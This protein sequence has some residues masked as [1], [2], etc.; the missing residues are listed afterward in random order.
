M[1]RLVVITTGGTIATGAGADGVLR[2]T[3]SGAELVGGLDAEVIELMSVDSSQLTPADWMKIGVAV[4]NAVADGA[5]GVVVTHGTDTMEETALWLEL[6]YGGE[7]PVV[8]TGAARP[9]D[10]PVPDGPR[11]LREALTVA[12]SPKT[13]GL[14]VLISFAGNVFAPLGTIK[15]GGPAV[16]GGTVPVGGVSGPAFLERTGK[17]RPYVGPVQ[18]VPRVDIAA[19]YP[20]AD[21]AAIDAF[22]AAGASGMV[23]EAMGPGNAGDAIVEAVERMCHLGVAVTV[24]S[25]VPGSGTR[26]EY[27]PAHDLVKAGAIMVPRLQAPQARVLMIAALGAGLPVADVVGWWG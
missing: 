15:Q 18:T 5:D 1:P 11:N 9:A 24:T 2:P 27:G 13:R 23:L 21:G 6:T 7:A 3:R 14:G 4:E 25:R 26:A 8:L 22:A 20:G 10:D 17:H 12:A 19:A 16:F